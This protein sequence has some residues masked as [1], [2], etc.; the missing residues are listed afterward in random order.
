M[1][2]ARMVYCRFCDQTYLSTDL[3]KC[4]LCRKSG[5]VVDPMSPAALSDLVTKKREE[6][7]AASQ[8]NEVAGA[9]L[10]AWRLFWLFAAGVAALAL[11]AFLLFSPALRANPNQWSVSDA[12]PGLAAVTVGVVLLGFVFW[13]WRVA[14][15]QAVAR[16]DK[17]KRA[18]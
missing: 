5:G 18:K 15:A 3:E 1:S 16:D 14:K 7:D 17:T 13:I 8:F 12:F 11:G 4:S 6:I 9:A 10:L 2:E